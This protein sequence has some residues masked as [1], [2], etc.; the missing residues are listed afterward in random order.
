MHWRAYVDE[1]SLEAVQWRG[2]YAATDVPLRTIH[3]ADGSAYPEQGLHAGQ[4]CYYVDFAGLTELGR[5]FAVQR[6]Q[7]TRGLSAGLAEQLLRRE[8]PEPLRLV[9]TPAVR[10]RM[11]LDGALSDRR[12]LEA[13]VAAY[14]EVL[15][16]NLRLLPDADPRLQ[17]EVELLRAWLAQ[18]EYADLHPL[19]QEGLALLTEILTRRQPG[20]RIA[21]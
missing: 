2:L 6:V 15:E 12:V 9:V 17:R 21:S 3:L 5:L 16:Q 18:R 13:G 14:R 7:E 1:D 4:P 19:M 8:R 20:P 10:C 11:Q